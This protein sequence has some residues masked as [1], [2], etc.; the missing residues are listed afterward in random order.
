MPISSRSEIIDGF[1][2]AGGE[3]L[4]FWS[5]FP[6]DQFAAPIGEAW[7][8]ADNV[9]HLIKSTRPV[10]KALGTSKMTLRMVFGKA[11]A[12][13]RSSDQLHQDYL[14]LLAQGGNAGDYAPSPVAPPT[15]PRAWQAELVEE[16]RNL[17]AELSTA[18][19]GWDE[20]DLDHYLLPHPLLGKLTVRE[21]LFFT[22]FHYQHHQE[23]VTRRLGDQTKAMGN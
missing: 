5:D 1:Q 8:P 4:R 7:S 9:R 20:A 3:G 14:N 10:I 13:S 2:L 21:V 19:D 23:N 15:D 16:L 12:L 11:S 18:I 6:P 17:I 22:L